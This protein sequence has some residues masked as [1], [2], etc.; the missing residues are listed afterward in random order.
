MLLI[1]LSASSEIGKAGQQILLSGGGDGVVKL[2]SIDSNTSRIEQ[3]RELSGGDS[4]V[5]S[6]VVQD[7]LLYC[8]LT[9]GEICIWDLD[10]CQLIRSVKAH[11]E[12]VLTLCIKETLCSAAA[13]VDIQGYASPS[14]SLNIIIRLS[15]MARNGTNALNASHAGN[16]TLA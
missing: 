1:S 11:C 7:S 6:M 12:D 10:T 5:L 8:G 14:T 3:M 15:F 9:D 13:Q 2:W 16:H 4:G